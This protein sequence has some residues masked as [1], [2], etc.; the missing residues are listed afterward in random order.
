MAFALGE[1]AVEILGPR[2]VLGRDTRRSGPM[3]VSALSAGV[4]S[5][6]GTILLA[7]VIPTPAIALLTRVF[8]ADGGVV[9]SA[10][11]NPPEYNGI[12]FFDAE[13]YKLS[14]ELEDAFEA[15]LAC[16]MEAL[17]GF[18]RA[19]TGL[20]SSADKPIGSAIGTVMPIS[21][22]ISIEEASERY[23]EHAI[24]TIRKQKLDLSGLTVAIDAAHGSA[25][26]TTPEAFRRLG[27]TVAT[28]NAD[29][30]G[31]YINADCG[32]TCLDPL[33]T[34][35]AR[36]RATLGIAHD[37]DADR[38]LAVDANGNEIDGDIIEAILAAD[39]KARGLLAH[40]TVVTTIMCNLGF[41]KAM[42]GKGIKVVQTDVGDS[43]V[44][45]AMREG[46]FV[47]GGEQ[48]GHLILLEHNSTGDG[49]ITA[50]QLAAAM[51]RSGKSLEELSHIMTRFP[52][53]L[54]NVP[55]K[56][57]DGFR[58][59]GPVAEAVEASGLRLG[60]RGRVLLRPSGTELLI[61]VMVEADDE[62]IAR[63]EAE[64]LAAVVEQELG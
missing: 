20:A 47:L 55:A 33:K 48:S 63:D 12:K 17:A 64:L 43:N 42:E 46:G 9:V 2:L 40:D 50:L 1:M 39:L 38:V 26:A 37:G 44:L 57:R 34:L 27:A 28:I 41:I 31:Y 7:G 60:S 45:A 59:S 30:N 24:G 14:K 18:N 15:R 49:L 11:H 29:S 61:R 36:S 35:V 10:S 6:G 58:S 56:N 19:E 8:K 52:Q 32:S 54:I 5:Q 3:L 62:Q 25:F 4:A 21:E 22:R 16:F 23:I 53:V 51:K 13:G